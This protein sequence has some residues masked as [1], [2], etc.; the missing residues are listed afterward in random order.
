MGAVT[1]MLPDSVLCSI[2][3]GKPDNCR[4]GRAKRAP[5]ARN[6]PGLVGL[7]SLDPPYRCFRN[8]DFVGGDSCRR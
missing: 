6:T 4:V 8:R 7:A 2:C 1:Q 5:P 3:C